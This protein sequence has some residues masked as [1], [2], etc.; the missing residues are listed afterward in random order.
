MATTKGA[1]APEPRPPNSPAGQMEMEIAPVILP[2]TL[3]ALSRLGQYVKD[4]SEKA[5]LDRQAAY[6]LRLAVDEIATNI[7]V[8][9]YEEAGLTGDILVQGKLNDGE[10]TIAVEDSGTPFDPLAKK[11]PTEEDL[12][13]PLEERPIG[14]LGIYLVLKGVD[15]FAYERSGNRNR[16]IFT[17]KRRLPGNGGN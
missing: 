4:A 7:I 10:I 11:L 14:G 9:G 15:K 2:A 6:N 8:H 5:G 16:N 13:R 3:D 17:M 1:G 12:A